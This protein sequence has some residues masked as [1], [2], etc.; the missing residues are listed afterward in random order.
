MLEGR[1]VKYNF[2]KCKEVVGVQ[3]AHVQGA[4]G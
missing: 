3:V 1:D 4:V 2:K